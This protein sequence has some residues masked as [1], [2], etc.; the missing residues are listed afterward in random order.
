MFSSRPSVTRHLNIRSKH[1]SSL[2]SAPSAGDRTTE[3]TGTR[4]VRL[5]AEFQPGM[6]EAGSE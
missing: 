6:N 3:A 4:T 2:P 1:Y 5:R